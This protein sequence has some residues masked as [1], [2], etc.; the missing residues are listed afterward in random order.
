MNTNQDQTSNTVSKRNLWK[1]RLFFMTVLM[2][3]LVLFSACSS[4][5]DNYYNDPS[6]EQIAGFMAVNTITDQEAVGVTIS[7]NLVSRALPYRSY[8]GGYVGIYPGQRS[9]DAF[10]SY[11]HNT[12]ATVTHT[13]EPGK[14]YSLFMIGV[15]DHYENVVVEDDLDGLEAGE[16]NVYVRFIN[17]IPAGDTPTFRV[18]ANG[19][20]L[21]SEEAAYGV[22]SDFTKVTA[23]E[24][25]M[26]LS[27]GDKIEAKRTVDLESNRV[28]TFLLVGNPENS[29]LSK[30][31]QIRY[32]EN[33][34][35]TE[36][37]ADTDESA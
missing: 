36:K 26:I 33:G 19:N 18:E 22:V 14:Y 25:D 24:L 10:S 31:V 11:N 9:V 17:A 32:I 37:E 21:F 2:A 23:G 4:D 1:P 30:E 28:Y 16:G 7:G 35:L 15:K 3:T 34:L 12:L 5:D 13:Y 8:T 6:W 29:D 27:D 20:E